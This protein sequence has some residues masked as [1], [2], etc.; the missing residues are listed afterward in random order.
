MK[1]HM[2][3]IKHESLKNYN[4]YLI[5]RKELYSLI[6]TLAENLHIESIILNYFKQQGEMQNIYIYI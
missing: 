1:T 3:T 5:N 6:K 2:R 4:L